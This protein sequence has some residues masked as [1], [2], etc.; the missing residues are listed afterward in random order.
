MDRNQLDE[1]VAR[2]HPGIKDS[3]K[4]YYT[5]DRSR[6]WVF[7]GIL[8]DYVFSRIERINWYDDPLGE[9]GAPPVVEFR[10]VEQV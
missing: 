2:I 8:N 7:H 6:R 9:D 3:A 5:W 4:T 1:D 10:V